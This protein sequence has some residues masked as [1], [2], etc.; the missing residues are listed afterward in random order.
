MTTLGATLPGNCERFAGARSARVFVPATA[1]TFEA[2]FTGDPAEGFCLDGDSADRDSG[3]PAGLACPPASLPGECPMATSRVA[4][5]AVSVPAFAALTLVGLMEDGVACAAS[6]RSGP[7]QPSQIARASNEIATRPSRAPKTT[8]RDRVPHPGSAVRLTRSD[9]SGIADRGFSILGGGFGAA[10]DALSGCDA[11]ARSANA[12][13]CCRSAIWFL[14]KA[15][16]W[17]EKTSRIPLT[18]RQPRIGKTA[19]ERNP[20]VRQ[21]SR[22]TSGSFS[23]SAQCWILPARKHSPEIPVFAFNCAP[24]T[25]ARSPLRARHTI[26][27]S[28]HIANAAAE[29]PVSSRATPTRVSSIGSRPWFPA[30][31][32]SFRNDRSALSSRFSEMSPDGLEEVSGEG[33]RSNAPGISAERNGFD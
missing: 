24:R 7:R 6:S 20:R 32:N 2:S 8:G 12:A 18:P 19:I 14:V 9:P 27:P 3:P 13:S 11:R 5:P 21:T 22:S 10:D 31:I 25:G 16:G 4:L 17:V 15:A 30:A 1:S 26:A 23:V 33:S 28:F 29:A